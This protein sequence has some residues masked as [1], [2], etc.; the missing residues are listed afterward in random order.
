MV[1]AI[2]AATGLTMTQF[3]KEKMNVDYA[4]WYY[5]F[6]KGKIKLED[7]HKIIF[8]TGLTFEELFPNPLK[9]V[10]RPISLN[11]SKSVPK[12]VVKKK[13]VSVTPDLPALPEVVNKEPEVMPAPLPISAP[14]DED[15]NLFGADLPT[16]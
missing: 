13:P 12:L 2:R 16:D 11:L 1:N 4:T 14:K 5:R 15:I 9:P 7:Y 6:K 8:Y 3:I 10:A